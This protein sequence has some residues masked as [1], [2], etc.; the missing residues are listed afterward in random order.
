MS[1]IIP[2]KAAKRLIGKP[3]LLQLVPCFGPYVPDPG[4][5]LPLLI[6]T[7]TVF[8]EKNMD[9]I[10]TQQLAK[11]F[12]EV[13]YGGNWT[14]VNL[15]DTLKDVSWEQAVAKV[16]DG[17]TI[18]VLVYHISYYVTVQLKVLNGGSLEGTDKDSFN[19]PPI[20]S[21]EDWEG[22]LNRVWK[23]ADEYAAL[24]EQFPDSRLNDYFVIEKYGTWLRNFLGLIEHTHYHLGQ[25]VFLKK[26]QPGVHK[27][28][29][30]AA[31]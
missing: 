10:L 17:N 30:G 18:A 11:H 9:R 29:S 5:I 24:A 14:W 21:K 7:G 26:M 4:C 23:E 2:R 1:T 12:R 20:R 6:F 28:E 3:L 15:R 16:H 19:C 13:Y 27:R 25:I 31:P 8:T 22:L